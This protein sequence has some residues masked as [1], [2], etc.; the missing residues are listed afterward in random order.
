MVRLVLCSI[1]A[2]LSKDKRIRSSYFGKRF[3]QAFVDFNAFATHASLLPL[4]TIS[5]SNSS[6]AYPQYQLILFVVDALLN[7]H[8]SSYSSLI[9][10]VHQIVLALNGIV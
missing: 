2:K 9:K 5:A 3:A 4:A 6:L 10:Q 7:V 1:F 8:V